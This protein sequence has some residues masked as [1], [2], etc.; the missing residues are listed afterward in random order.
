[1]SLPDIYAQDTLNPG[2]FKAKGLERLR[3]RQAVPGFELAYKDEQRRGPV[4]FGE[5]RSRF[6]TNGAASPAIAASPRSSPRASARNSRSSTTGGCCRNW[7]ISS[8]YG[9]G[10]FDENRDCVVRNENYGRI[11]DLPQDLLDAQAPPAD[12]SV[13]LLLRSR[14]FRPIR[15]PISRPIRSLRDVQ[16]AR[17]AAVERRLGNGRWVEWR[18]AP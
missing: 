13:P 17:T 1:M 2:E 9:I 3:A 11:L 12:R 10:V 14:R 7:S 6:S 16:A 15:T 8:P 5:R 18:V 4:V